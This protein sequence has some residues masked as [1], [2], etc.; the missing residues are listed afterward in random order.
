V[1]AILSPAVIGKLGIKKSIIFS[2]CMMSMFAFSLIPIGW[3]ST[4]T[5]EERAYFEAVEMGNGKKSL[6][7]FFYS[8]ITCKIIL[9]IGNVCT[10]IA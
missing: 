8:E 4:L 10:G 2:A 7:S 3:R 1:F 5:H 9:V 6:G